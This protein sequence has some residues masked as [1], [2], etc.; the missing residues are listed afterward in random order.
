MPTWDNP[1]V[2]QTS[3]QAR[4][5][6]AEQF[7]AKLAQILDQLVGYL[8]CSQG[9]PPGTPPSAKVRELERII[10]SFLASIGLGF[11]DAAS[12]ATGIAKG[13]ADGMAIALGLATLMADKSV[14]LTKNWQAAIFSMFP[15][16]RSGSIS[17]PNILNAVNLSHATT[18]DRHQIWMASAMPD[19]AA[20]MY[21]LSKFRQPSL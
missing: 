17:L 5:Q 15:Q 8:G 18:L 4:L 9:V 11:S 12:L 10:A 19:A 20:R 13:G 1:T 7:N 16:L 14:G 3:L 21:L 6:V 2:S